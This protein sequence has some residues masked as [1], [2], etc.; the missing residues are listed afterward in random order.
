LIV[1]ES[2]KSI[3]PI[4]SFAPSARLGGARPLP[5]GDARQLTVHTVFI[6]LISMIP[7]EMKRQAVT[8]AMLETSGANLSI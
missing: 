2:T 5:E 4:R 1:L 7:N 6:Q 3:T 8:V